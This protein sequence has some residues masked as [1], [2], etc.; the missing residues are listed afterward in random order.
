MIVKEYVNVL[1]NL[2]NEIN[3]VNYC[4]EVDENGIWWNFVVFL[5]RVGE[6]FWLRRRYCDRLI[7]NMYGGIT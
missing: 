1:E 6:K 7:I 3:V 2:R 4:R 5:E